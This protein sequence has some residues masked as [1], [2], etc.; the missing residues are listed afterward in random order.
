MQPMPLDE[1]VRILNG[2]DSKA[3]AFRFI[4]LPNLYVLRTLFNTGKIF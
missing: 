2:R 1:H 3:N 4:Q